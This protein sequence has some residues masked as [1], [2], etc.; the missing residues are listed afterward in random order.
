MTSMPHRSGSG[1]AVAR[2]EGAERYD[3]AIRRARLGRRLYR[4]LELRAVARALR[5]AR[6]ES[7]LD[8]PCGSGRLDPL[9]RAR[10]PVVVGLD[11]SAAM[12][13]IYRRDHPERVGERGDAFAL[14]YADASFD[15]V[16]SHRLLHHLDSDERRLALLRSFA[17]VASQ[18][19][20]VYA[21]LEVPL[22]HARHARK[23][24]TLAHARR[25]LARAGLELEAVYFAAWPLQ[26]KAELVARKR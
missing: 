10:F 20:I 3:L 5:H 24:I 25:L 14:P 21:W 8:C 23:A 9:L 12:L 2:P 17:R 7:V 4:W 16:V 1:A 22:R 6:G 13:G 26:A 19:V 18:G 15:W 11:R